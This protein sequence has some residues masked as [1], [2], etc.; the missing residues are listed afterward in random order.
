MNG[1]SLRYRLLELVANRLQLDPR[2][3]DSV[4]VTIDPVVYGPNVAFEAL[5]HDGPMTHSLSL[6]FQRDEELW[7]DGGAQ[8]GSG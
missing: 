6:L 3:I 5:A 8:E 2:Q 4:K 1:A 7:S